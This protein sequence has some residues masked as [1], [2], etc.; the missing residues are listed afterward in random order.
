MEI[1]GRCSRCGRRRRSRSP[2]RDTL[3]VDSDVPGT[4]QLYALPVARRRA[5]AADEFGRA[6]L[7]AASCPTAGCSSRSTR[8]GTSGRSSTCST[9]A[10]SSRSSSTRASS[11]HR[12]TSRDGS[13]A[14]VFDEPA[15]RRRL[16][17][18]RPRPAHRRG[19]RLRARRLVQRR[20]RCPRRP[21]DRRRTAR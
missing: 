19:A 21:L 11:T 8:A 1:C 4:R 15:E 2:R 16:R 9:A 10:S 5:R 13:A 6:G 3:L 12:R 7:R 20:S 14:R 18:R 17:H